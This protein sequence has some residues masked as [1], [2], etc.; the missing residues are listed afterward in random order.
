MIGTEIVRQPAVA[1]RK[2]QNNLLV[3]KMAARMK[4]S[5]IFCY[6]KHLT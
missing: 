4:K 5:Y 1:K 2:Q 3:Q 6:Y